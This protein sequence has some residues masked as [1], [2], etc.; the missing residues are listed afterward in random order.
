MLRHVG[1][2]QEAYVPCGLPDVFALE[3][4]QGNHT[5]SPGASTAKEKGYELSRILAQFQEERL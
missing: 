3:R 2:E 4:E 5:P 1:L